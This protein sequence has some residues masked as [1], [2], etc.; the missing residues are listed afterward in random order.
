[1]RVNQDYHKKSKDLNTRLGGDQQGGF[2]PDLNTFGRDGVVLG[3]IV[4]AGA[5]TAEHLAYYGDRGS[6]T[7]TA[8]YRRVLYRT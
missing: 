4:G 6:A 1:M 2:D 5:L 8:Y 7:V 3:P